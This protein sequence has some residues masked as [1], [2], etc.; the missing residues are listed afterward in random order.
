[1]PTGIPL[2][3]APPLRLV[4]GGPG[5]GKTA[6]VFRELK[7]SL[8]SGRLIVPTATLVRHFQHELARD[9]EVFPPSAVISLSRFAAERAAPLRPCP[10]GLLRALVRD[11]LRR[12]AP[13]EFQSVSDTEGMASTLIETIALFEN[14][15]ATPA[16]LSALRK[17][18]GHAKAFAALWSR[19]SDRMHE[20]GF[21]SRGEILRA[22]AAN[23]QG[24]KLHGLK[25]W[26]DG[27]AT[28]SPLETEFIHALTTTCAVTVTTADSPASIEFR[29]TALQW[30]CEE[31][32]LQ[33]P[34]RRPQTTIVTAPSLEREADEIARRIVELHAAG[35]P[36]GDI[37]VGVRDA[38]SWHP[39]LHA[40]FERFGIPARFY[41]SRPLRHHPA[42]VFLGGLVN[43]VLEGWEFGAALEAFRAHPRWGSSAAFDRFDFKVREAMPGRGAD[44]LLSLCE[45][46]RLKEN[47]A[48]CFAVSAWT[49]DKRS[50]ELWAR[51][52]RSLAETLYR[53]GL[54]DP[55]RD[56]AAIETLRSQAAALR[57]WIEAVE[58]VVDF[59]RGRPELIN[60]D[61]IN[62][63]AFWR[64]A[65]EALDAASVPAHDDRRDVV[66][67]MHVYEV[68]QW[69]VATLFVCGLTDRDFPRKNAQNLL[70]PDPEI[71]AIRR[72]G[73]PLRKAADLDRD[74]D[75]LFESLKGRARVSLVLSYAQHD[76]GGRR[77]ESSRFVA[78]ILQSGALT[79]QTAPLCR[80]APAAEPAGSGVAGRIDSPGLL[81]PLA[82]RHR[83][84]SLTALE[85]LAQCRFKFFAGRTLGLKKRPERPQERLQPRVT[86]LILHQALEDWLNNLRQGDFTAFF[87]NAF[88]RACREMHLPPG[89]RLEVERM[90]FR[91]IASKVTASELWQ[92][93]QSEVE[94][95]LTI[96]FPGG[97]LVK[98]RIDRIDHLTGQDCII[99]DYKSS[100]TARV[101][102]FLDSPVK[103]QGPLY[104][105]AARERRGLNTVA[106][107][108]HAVREDKRFGWGH[109]PGAPLEL[110]PM[111]ENWAEDAKARAVERIS[112]FLAGE[113][114]AQPVE[115]GPCRWCD[116]VS[117]CRFGERAGLVMIEGAA[118]A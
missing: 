101:E 10:P 42:A 66:H 6:L 22:A 111:P 77:T 49:L 65:S 75:A 90:E 29:R 86:G 60:P 43:N 40:A 32:L 96:D 18:K 26:F 33:A 70:F 89:Y 37:G 48:E 28:F 39:L 63:E 14:A 97:I 102:G 83:E 20:C 98:C 19:I 116:F 68:R 21:A 84:I 51:R 5:A 113:I 103:L 1:V 114:H 31:K 35:R 38:E 61:P 3:F 71:D 95:E 56:F 115:R 94:V 9:G 11:I 62:L 41:F 23:T 107:M 100:K 13:P 110:R 46:E 92:A 57:A 88:E 12:H 69:D 55:P 117:A 36:F 104:A 24:L 109:V 91:K 72:Q 118:G 99:V 76:G 82:E 4:R 50:P 16:K 30:R 74:E 108:Y 67:V 7:Q 15:G 64:V 58:S 53:P 54:I 81:A 85:D 44:A 105:L 78:E 8:H 34:T 79:A 80:P 17:L 52:L 45:D 112:G 25:L 73:I 2:F 59:W 106:M 27:F 47:L 93:S 87:D